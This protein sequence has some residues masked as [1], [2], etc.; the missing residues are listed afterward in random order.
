MNEAPPY[1]YISVFTL[2]FY[3]PSEE[4][5]P[6]KKIFLSSFKVLH[7]KRFCICV[8]YRR[9]EKKATKMNLYD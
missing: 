2:S 5:S 9:D 8:N 1:F 3:D 6:E 7:D 4:K